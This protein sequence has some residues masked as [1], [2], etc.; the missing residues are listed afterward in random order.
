MKNSDLHG[1]F[2]GIVI[3]IIACIVMFFLME[4]AWDGAENS[5]TN[6]CDNYGSFMVDGIKYNCT[7]VE[8]IKK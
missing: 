4:S 6:N 7:V 5:I 3:S 2:I 1:V 8:G